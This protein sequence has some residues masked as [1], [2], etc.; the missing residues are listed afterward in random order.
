MKKRS[1]F[2]WVELIFGIILIVLGVFTF[3]RPSSA[4]TGVVFIYGLLAV[5]T[6][7]ADVIFYAKIEK[8]TGFGPAV[9][10]VTGILSIIVG[11]LLL[12]NLGA[13]KWALVILFPLWFIMH[14]I[15][16]LTHLNI[17]RL[18][19]GNGY[20][21]FTLIVNILGLLLGLIMIFNPLI[22]FLSV[23]YIIGFYLILI[24]IDHFVLAASRI[25]M[26]G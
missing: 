3:A 26:R 23:S 22:S 12:F 5:I 25:G 17:I 7:I 1:A 2:G 14:C 8:R 19:A 13:G 21:Y 10:L 24:G 16:R 20:Y 15:S 6:G 11:I 4:L 9:A 18:T